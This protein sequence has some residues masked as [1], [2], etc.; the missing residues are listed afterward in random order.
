VTPVTF[1]QSIPGEWL[2]QYR[3]LF[4][5]PIMAGVSY[6]Y[7]DW[8]GYD[9]YRVGTHVPTRQPPQQG[10]TSD[11]ISPARKAAR[12]FLMSIASLWGL[13]TDTGTP[14]FAYSGPC[15][16]AWWNDYFDDVA[17]NR[18]QRFVG[19][20][21]GP[22][23]GYGFVLWADPAPDVGWNVVTEVFPD[24]TWQVPLG[25]GWITYLMSGETLVQQ[26]YCLTL[27][28]GARRIFFKAASITFDNII[29][30]DVRLILERGPA[31]W[32]KT[33]LTWN[34]MPGPWTEVQRWAP[35]DPPDD[36]AF[37]VDATCSY[38]LRFAPGSVLREV[39]E[40]NGQVAVSGITLYGHA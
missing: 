36:Q 20:T 21:W 37:P 13:Q 29:E 24:A 38:R 39:E 23:E 35:G 15:D 14:T 2:D 1:R 30:D 11:M 27:C 12:L 34:N 40:D 4:G 10:V 6:K 28:A 17:G 31:W 3:K 7:P 26:N 33:T 18:Y 16:Q 9:S 19:A 22:L 5:D 25:G 8:Y 32:D